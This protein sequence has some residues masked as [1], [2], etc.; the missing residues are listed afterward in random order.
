[1]IDEKFRRDFSEVRRINKQIKGLNNPGMLCAILPGEPEEKD[2]FLSYR[3][4][5][6]LRI[7]S[8]ISKGYKILIEI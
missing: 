5:S 3:E 2:I 4:V 6:L 7:Y 1:M 8:L